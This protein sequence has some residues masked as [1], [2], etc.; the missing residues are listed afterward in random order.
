MGDAGSFR[1]DR[2]TQGAGST[3]LSNTRT[4]TEVHLLCRA[5]HTD[6]LTEV[7]GIGPVYADRLHAAGIRSFDDI[8]LAT[9]AALAKAADVSEARVSSWRA[10]ARGLAGT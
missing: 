9:D 2:R 8:A 5:S 7:N 3:E 4:V 1:F 6:D 10:A